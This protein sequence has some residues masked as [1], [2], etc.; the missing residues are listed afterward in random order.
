MIEQDKTLIL[1]SLNYSD[2]DYTVYNDRYRNVSYPDASHATYAILVRIGRQFYYI[3]ISNACVLFNPIRL[4]ESY[5]FK[6]IL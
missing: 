4:R 6:R 2:V 3:I 1:L 5:S